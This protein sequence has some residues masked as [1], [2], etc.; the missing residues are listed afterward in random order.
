MKLSSRS[1][2]NPSVKRT[3]PGV[4]GS[5][6]YLKRWVSEMLSRVF[7]GL[8]IAIYFAFVG[9]LVGSL[10]VSASMLASNWLDGPGGAAAPL[11]GEWPV[12]STLFFFLTMAMFGVAAGFIPA[13]L[14]GLVYA[15]TFH[16]RLHSRSNPVL[17]ASLAGALGLLVGLLFSRTFPTTPGFVLAGIVAGIFCSVA[18][19]VPGHTSHEGM[20]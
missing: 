11:S 7:Q 3:A 5:A 12:F 1:E 19:R 8:W 14:V 15:A 2:P 6:A 10:V 4:P 17:K 16:S 18:V 20:Q 13:G 9:P